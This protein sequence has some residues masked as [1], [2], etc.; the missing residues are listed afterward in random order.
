MGDEIKLQI[1]VEEGSS[2]RTVEEFNRALEKSGSAALRADSAFQMFISDMSPSELTN[3]ARNLGLVEIK[4][5]GVKDA[6]EKA[7]DGARRF[8]EEQAKAARP[9]GG[10][11]LNQGAFQGPL[12][13]SGALLSPFSVVSDR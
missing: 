3:A 10:A 6:L 1:N 5:N 4:V 7:A 9:D 13:S 12:Q 2:I 11:G 8:R